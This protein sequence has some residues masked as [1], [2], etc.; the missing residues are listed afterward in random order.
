MGAAANQ[1]REM[2]REALVDL[3]LEYID[4]LAEQEAEIEKLKTEPGLSREQ[5][6]ELREAL[7]EYHYAGKHGDRNEYRDAQE[8]LCVI[9]ERLT[10]AVLGER[11]EAEKEG[12][13]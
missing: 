6:V 3:C 13:G 12:G 4:K 5:A 11:G 1:L 10:N 7:E 8:N 2:S 9:C